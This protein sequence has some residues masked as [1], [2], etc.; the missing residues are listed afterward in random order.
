MH[1]RKY[2]AMSFASPAAAAARR[3]KTGGDDRR[4]TLDVAALLT[5]VERTD[6]ATF[7][8]LLRGAGAAVSAPL[9]A[10]VGRGRYRAPRAGAAPATATCLHVAAAYG[11]HPIVRWLLHAGA[12]AG[13][14]DGGGLTPL[15]VAEDAGTTAELRASTMSPRAATAAAGT[16]RGARGGGDAG[17]GV[18]GD[19]GFSRSP[20]ARA[21]DPAPAMG[22]C[23]TEWAPAAAAAW[24]PVLAAT[25]ASTLLRQR[26]EEARVCARARAF[27][28]PVLCGVVAGRACVTLP[29]GRSCGSLKW[30]VRGPRRW[31]RS[32]RGTRAARRRRALRR[33]ARSWWTPLRTPWMGT[34]RAVSASGVRP[35]CWAWGHWAWRCPAA[36]VAAARCDPRTCGAT[37]WGW[38]RTAGADRRRG[39]PPRRR[40]RRLSPTRSGR[41]RCETCRR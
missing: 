25:E 9:F 23:I 36:A 40:P 35:R 12:D 21:R 3:V 7:A 22:E 32:W 37:L 14:V 29:L 13:A 16:Q 26:V 34:F 18:G 38:T 30:L 2:S 41:C 31:K 6:L 28:A 27:V 17:S 24:G 20:A 11:A 33:M 5:A 1:S 8:S 39:P 15:D 10:T 4:G 19:G